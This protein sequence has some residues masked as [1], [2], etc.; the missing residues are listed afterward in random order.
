MA[1]PNESSKTQQVSTEQLFEVLVR[2]H[3]ARLRAF[4]GS[5]VRDPGTVEDLVQEAFLVAWRNLDRYDR[6]MPFGPWL[7]GI[8]R[9]LALAHYRR[10]TNEKLD[11]FDEEVITTLSN[12]HAAFEAM[13]GDTLAEQL[14]SLRACFGHLPEHQQR[15][16]EMH[17]SDELGC[18]EIGDTLG[19]SR[20]AVKKL[21]QR[22]RAWLSQ[23]IEQR[24]TALGDLS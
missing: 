4:L 8:G 17:Y 22:G 14:S 6:S 13:P 18:G 15:V 24:M 10:S 19:R 3:E 21:L 23:C 11:F 2:D 9:K 7:R 16:I 20:E 12:L 5:F 1:Q